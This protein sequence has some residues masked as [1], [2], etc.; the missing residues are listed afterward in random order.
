VAESPAA[1]GFANPLQNPALLA[2]PYAL[3]A[4]LR[5]SQPVFPVPL[6]VP[7]RGA[8]VWVLTR[9]AEVE[10][11][12]RDPRFSVERARAD[13]VRE[14]AERL[15]APLLGGPGGLRT[16][17][18]MDPPDHTRV[19]G[20]VSKAFTPR[21]VAALVP[22]I[23]ALA[24]E[25]IRAA[26]SQ[27]GM[28]V[29]RDLAEPLP[30][31]VIAELLGVPPED[32][33]RFRAWSSRLILEMPRSLSGGA[34]EGMKVFATLLDYLRGVIAERRAAPRDDLISAM[35]QAQEQRDALSDPELVSTSLLLLIAGHETTTNL[36]G[37]GLLALLRHPEQLELLRGRPERL[38]HGIEELL[39]YDSPVQG[40]LRVAL[41]DVELGGRTLP[42]GALV[43]CGIGA[44][45]RDP[46]AFPDPDRLDVTRRDVHHLSFG[47]GAHFCLGAALARL[48]A[49]AAFRALLEQLPGLALASEAV[50]YRPN[51]LLRGLR[52][53]PVTW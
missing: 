39:R 31:I 24:H 37:N 30:A 22:R 18:V 51:L 14:Y 2:N 48:E 15:P 17:L 8:G 52:A 19:R 43:F 3:Y 34:E 23:D 11:A 25:C 47:L 10:R 40:T 45:N 42:A 27:G 33:R 4:A 5:A 9:Y 12:L 36:V 7:H 35:V 20:L 21:R 38:E 44:A 6:P 13:I 26:R 1:S 28:D 29:I 46:E 50:E 49:R 41:E 53:L 16:M 32:H